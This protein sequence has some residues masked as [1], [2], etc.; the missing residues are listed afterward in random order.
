M[1]SEKDLLVLGFTNPEKAAHPAGGVAAWIKNF[2]WDRPP[3]SGPKLDH[4][5][6]VTSRSLKDAAADVKLV[7]V[8]EGV[9]KDAEKQIQHMKIKSVAIL[10]TGVGAIGALIS[11]IRQRAAQK[12][13]PTQAS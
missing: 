2:W 11:V 9:I 8:I 13:E 6:E 4:L 5:K 10:A 7:D 1:V 12:D 3:T